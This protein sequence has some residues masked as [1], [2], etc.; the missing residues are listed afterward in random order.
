MAPATPTLEDRRTKATFD[1]FAEL[2]CIRGGHDAAA[3][4]LTIDDVALSIATTRTQRVRQNGL[5]NY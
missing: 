1:L 2:K 3:D 5:L 4:A